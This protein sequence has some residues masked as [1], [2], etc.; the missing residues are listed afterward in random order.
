MKPTS[1]A[2][3]RSRETKGLTSTSYYLS[4][5]EKQ[6]ILALANKLRVSQKDAILIAVRAFGKREISRDALLAE[7]AA[8]LR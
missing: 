3:R 4:A 7:I 5:A 8:R 6:D 1:A 2:V